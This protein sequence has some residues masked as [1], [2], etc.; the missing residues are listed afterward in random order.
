MLITPSSGGARSVDSNHIHRMYLFVE[1]FQKKHF[2]PQQSVTVQNE[3]KQ[4]T[5]ADSSS[6]SSS[7]SSAKPQLQMREEGGTTTQ[8]SPRS[9]KKPAV[10]FVIFVIACFDGYLL[11][12]G[13]GNMDVYMYS[14]KKQR[15][16]GR[17]RSRLRVET[18][19]QACFG[20]MT[21]A[22]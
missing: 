20:V 19:R 17:F 8:S 21:A 13:R 4:N 18:K 9:C 2:V 12:Y 10:R 1:I 16:R 22:V 6:R 11:R 7:S 14:A 3:T 5:G 15:R